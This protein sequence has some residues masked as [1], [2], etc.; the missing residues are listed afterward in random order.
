MTTLLVL[1]GIGFYLYKKNESPKS[2]SDFAASIETKIKTSPIGTIGSGIPLGSGDLSSSSG[3]ALIFSP[4]KCACS[5]SGCKCSGGS[6]G[7]LP[8][9]PLQRVISAVQS[10]SNQPTVSSSPAPS[11]GSPVPVTAYS[12]STGGSRPL[13]F[14]ETL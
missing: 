7:P 6:T 8:V 10:V 13:S 5:G 3:I 4:A 11:A 9:S 12:G 1:L 2:I 14:L